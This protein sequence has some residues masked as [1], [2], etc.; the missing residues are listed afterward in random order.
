[1]DFVVDLVTRSFGQVVVSL[2]HNWPYLLASVVIAVVL[3][4][5]VDAGRISAFLARHRGAGVGV[6]TAAAVGTPLCSCGTTAVVLGMMASTMPWAPIVA[7]MVASPLSSPEG[8][9]YTAGLFGWPFAIGMFAASIALG[10]TGGA[11]ATTLERRGLLQGQARLAPSPAAA[12][13]PVLAAA[14]LPVA[15]G[16]AGSSTRLVRLQR[17]REG[18]ARADGRH[19]QPPGRPAARPPEHG[20]AAPCHVLRIC[21][22][23]L[24]PEQPHSR[25]MGLRSLRHREGL[26]RS[27]R[28][29]YRPST[30]CELR[31]ISA[32]D[33]RAAGL[34]H[35]PGSCHGIPDCRVRYLDRRDCRCL[36]DCPVARCR[37]W[38]SE[39]CG[40]APWRLG[41]ATISCWPCA[42]SERVHDGAAAHGLAASGFT[43][44]AVSTRPASWG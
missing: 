30:V 4:T 22:H 8:M 9:V 18:C 2:L 39:Y 38:W 27:P 29:H 11:V 16:S 10:L 1:M 12:R 5:F 41:S 43:G 36:D 32:D 21:L 25:R 44:P 33:T 34:R 31:G 35:E 28:C 6:A 7:F 19:H 17:R 40:W 14:R 23:R 42:S 26:R 15:R 3:K 37:A 13:P 20:R 24:P